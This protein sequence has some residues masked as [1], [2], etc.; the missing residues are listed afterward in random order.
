MI[1]IDQIKEELKEIKTYYAFNSKISDGAKLVGDNAVVSLIDKYNSAIR[2]AKA[3]LYAAYIIV[4]VKGL[5]HEEAAYQLHYSSQ[6]ME[7]LLK[8]LFMY[9]KKT[10]EGGARNAG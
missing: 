3:N 8:N 2:S 10:F 7:R 6:H 4:Y 1:S 9:F 5:S